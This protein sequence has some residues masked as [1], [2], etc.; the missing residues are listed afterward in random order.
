MMRDG[1]GVG[2]RKGHGRF[3]TFSLKMLRSVRER[4]PILQA[5]HE[6]RATQVR[7]MSGKFRGVPGGVGWRVIHRDHTD[8]RREPPEEIKRFIK[9]AERIIERPSATYCPTFTQL[10]MQLEDDLL[11]IN[12]PVVEVLHSMF[13][14]RRVVG[15]RAVDGE[16]IWPTLE[17]V[18]KWREDNPKWFKHYDPNELTTADVL[19]LACETL[20]FDLHGSEFCLVREGVLEQVYPRHRLIVAPIVNRTSIDLA[21]YPPS[22][23][24]MAI[25][26][27]LAFINAW[28][29]N[30]SFFTKGMLSEFILG[31]SGDV[32]P[33]DMAAFVDMF[34]ESTQGVRRAHQPPIMPLP[35]TGAIQKID[36]KA[37]NKDMMYEVWLSLLIAL[38]TAIYRM[39]PSTV[40]A[41]PWDGGQGSRLGEASRG[42]EIA[43]AKE[44]GL[45]G[46]LEHLGQTVLTPLV[47]RCHPDLLFEFV[48]PE[49]DQASQANLLSTR[50]RTSIT[51]NEVR[52]LEGLSPMGFWVEPEKMDSLSEKDQAKFDANV[53]NMPTDPTFV[54]YQQQKAM[55]EQQEQQEAM[56][57]EQQEQGQP[58]EDDGYGQP[59][60]GQEDAAQGPPPEDDGYGQPA[61][62]QEDDGYGQSAPS[63][64][65]GEDPGMTKARP[66]TI[67]VED[68]HG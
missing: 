57:Q 55:Q 40:N 47:Q 7:A 29:Y 3:E 15:V 19:D 68:I 5:I 50:A 23:V 52:L 51:R 13:D 9:K 10:M 31:V 35:D 37:P 1:G 27:I 30:E 54:N 18:E 41:K 60:A 11:T 34:R 66:I 4:A 24:E 26:V 38:S 44:E 61:G 63:Y 32:H 46:D 58:P 43:S 6:A 45:K 39:D 17:W 65:F 53:W 12:R 25:Q 2:V 59:A 48:Y 62:G 67:Y 22:R 33:D 20:D 21:G 64:P 28:D 56:Q 36:L 16:M 42:D 14:Q 8:H 49:D